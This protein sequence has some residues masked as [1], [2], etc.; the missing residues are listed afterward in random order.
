MMSAVRIEHGNLYEDF[1]IGHEFEHH[2]GKT[3]TQAEN[4]IFCALTMQYGPLYVNAE[5]ARKQGYRN[6]PIH[7][8]LIVMT[9]V[10]L[11]VEDLTER[12]G[13]F[14]GIDDLKFGEPFY[15]DD[16]LVARSTVLEKREAKSRPGWGIV[17]WH[18]RSFN[19]RDAQVVEYRRTN[20]SRMRSAA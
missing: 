13:P 15:P 11:S 12:G 10:G 7:P 3:I 1:V 14:L 4:N 5:Y 20:F 2:W 6:C 18:T 8:L 19:Q 16:T 17:T 9:T